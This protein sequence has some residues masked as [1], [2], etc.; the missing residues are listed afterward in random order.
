MR[1]RSTDPAGRVLVRPTGLVVAPTAKRY[2]SVAPEGRP[3]TSTCTVWSLAVAVVSV[4]AA[5]IVPAPKDTSVPI[6][7][8]AVTPGPAVA[9]SI[10]VHSTTPSVVG[11]PDSTP[12]GNAATGR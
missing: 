11:S 3:A 9:G 4:P 5:R 2:Q 7:Q 10:R 12:E 6:S 8:R 1:I